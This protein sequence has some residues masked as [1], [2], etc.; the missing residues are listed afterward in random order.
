M[1]WRDLYGNRPGQLI[2]SHD[3]ASRAVPPSVRQ[4]GLRTY[5]RHREHVLDRDK[6]ICQICWLP[7]DPSAK[8]TDDRYPTIDHILSVAFGGD[9]EPDNLRTAHLWCNVMVGD[10]GLVNDELVRTGTRKRFS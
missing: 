1:P 3:D 10:A 9:D 2:E 7:A 5:S 4:R 6:Y 8:Q